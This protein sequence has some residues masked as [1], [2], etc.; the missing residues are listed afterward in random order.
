MNK[1]LYKKLQNDSVYALVSWLFLRGLA[2]IYFAAFASM[3]GQIEGLIGENGILPIQSEL[4][5]IARHFPD[6]KLAVFPTVFWFDASDQTLR[7]VC[8]AGMTAATMLL[9]SVFERMAL[10]LCY[11]LYLSITVA[12]QDFTSFQ[13]DAFLL[14]AGFLALLLTWGSP[15]CIFLYRWLI[16]RFMF[17]GGVVK[18]A[19]GDP[20]WANLS[21]L[22]YHYQTEPLPSPLAYYAYFLPHW[23]NELCVIGVFIIELIVP[24]FVFM[25]RRFRLFAAW[26]FIILQSSI[27]LTGNYNFFNL[28]TILLC[29]F[30]FEDRDIEKIVP[31]RFVDFIKQQQ[32]HPGAAANVIAAFWMGAVLLTCLTHVWIYNVR[33]PTY[34]LL[35]TWVQL[36]SSYSL[37]NN[38]GPFAI[39]TTERPEIIVQGSNDGKNWL[40]YQFKY[41]PVNLDK[42]L[43]WN[44]PHQPRLDWQMW[45]AAIETPGPDS[46]FAKFMQKLQ[47]GSP[48][49]LSLLA[50]N[51]FPEQP[52]AFVRA[53]SYRY[54][55]TTPEQR[56]ATGNIWLREYLGVYWPPKD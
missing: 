7:M 32:T 27:I 14:E 51:P 4:A 40:A 19:S 39:M 8:Y 23:V 16:A 18:L 20:S 3:A 13:W 21:A 43:G 28:L 11:V 29:L 2:L 50:G 41:K 36:I 47:E 42:K 44:I 10:I 45:F 37:V 15:I 30:I 1:K 56:A 6:R 25:P 33:Q 54:F 49:V 46:W 52:P 55:Y 31:V 12:G 17:M 38:Y 5:A 53:L 9:F 26:S 22:S 34:S 35:K 24:F 48:Q